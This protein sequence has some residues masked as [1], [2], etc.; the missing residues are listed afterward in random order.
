MSAKCLQCGSAAVSS[1]YP[2]AFECGTLVD[3]HGTFHHT[4]TCRY[5]F[6]FRKPLDA[7]IKRLEVAGDLLRDRYILENERWDLKT[8]NDWFDAKEAK[9]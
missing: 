5:F 4:T 3:R 8:V 9:P 6:E 7:H 1:D 2:R